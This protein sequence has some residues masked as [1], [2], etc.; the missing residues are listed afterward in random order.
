MSLSVHIA[1]KAGSNLT[2]RRLVTQVFS[3]DPPAAT[4]VRLHLPGDTTAETWRSRQQGLHLIAQ[5]A[6]AGIRNVAT[7]TDDEWTEQVAMEHLAVLSVVARWADE[8]VLVEPST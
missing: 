1:Q 3:P 2:E 7:H 5:G 6:F 4:Q 8:T